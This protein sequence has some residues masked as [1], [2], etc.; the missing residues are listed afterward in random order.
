MPKNETTDVSSEDS[1]FRS[2]KMAPVDVDHNHTHHLS[3]YPSTAFGSFFFQ[4]ERTLTPPAPWLCRKFSSMPLSRYSDS[5]YDFNIGS[6]LQCYHIKFC[7]LCRLNLKTPAIVL[8]MQEP[9]AMIAYALYAVLKGPGRATC[10]LLSCTI[11]LQDK[12][13][14]SALFAGL[15]I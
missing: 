2:N 1:R 12:A 6:H 5:L 4:W 3:I 8:S 11:Q 15:P 10:F 13:K 9:I 14:G 7:K